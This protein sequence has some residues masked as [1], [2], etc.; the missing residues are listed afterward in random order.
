[1]SV[2]S[3]VCRRIES[4]RGPRS[5]GGTAL[6]PEHKYSP[7]IRFFMLPLLGLR[8]RENRTRDT[9]GTPDLR[10]LNEEDALFQSSDYLL[11]EIAVTSR[12]LNASQP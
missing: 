2:A 5:P 8:D 1:M 7:A 11:I 4:A 9:G 3:G 6:L 12:D 10:W